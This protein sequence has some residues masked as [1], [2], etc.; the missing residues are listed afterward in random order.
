MNQTQAALLVAEHAE[1][2]AAAR[3]AVAA[4][5]RD[6]PDPLVHVRHVLTA[7]DQMPAPGAH[8]A[9]LLA[10]ALPTAHLQAL[11]RTPETV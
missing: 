9:Q 3:A 7:H 4:A 10:Q 5:E 6:E 11:I 2:L 8:P 1:L